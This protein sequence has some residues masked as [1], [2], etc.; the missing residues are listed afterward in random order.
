[1]NAP[2]MRR[3]TSEH[4]ILRPRETSR[5]VELLRYPPDADTGRYVER[6]WAV[7]WDLTE[8]YD[9][10]LIPHPCVNLTFLPG[11]GGQ[12]HGVGTRPSTH[13]LRDTGSVFGVKFRPGGFHA[14]TSVP[15]APLVDKSRPLE[16]VFGSAAADLSSAVLAAEG[17][18]ER[19][20]TVASFLSERLP[21][22]PDPQYSLLLDAVS[23]MLDDCTVTRVDGVAE[24]VG[25]SV[26]TI[27][28]AFREYVGVSPKWIIRRY[29]MHDG[30]ERLAAG[31]DPST[32]AADLG[33]FDQA[34]FTRDFTALI[35]MTPAAYVR[36]NADD[37]AVA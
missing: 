13:P 19:V 4:G 31:E 37:L 15:V 24:R 17:D 36:A 22:A 12:V 21:E 25:V 23:V 14:L 30:A 11:V 3:T 34:H 6:H 1:M 2:P 8:P 35:G 5:H 29:R 26:R 16:D 10:Q 32:V 18:A 28:R 20:R 7:H 27:Q 33:W 9:V